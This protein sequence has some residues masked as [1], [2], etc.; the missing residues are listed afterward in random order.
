[1]P[2]ED[3]IDRMLTEEITE[4]CQAAQAK[5]DSLPADSDILSDVIGA[6]LRQQ[7]D[8]RV[9]SPPMGKP[10]IAAPYHLEVDRIRAFE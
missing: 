2:L 4:F 3:A 1:M 6:L 10:G 7:D 9:K 5:R 8:L